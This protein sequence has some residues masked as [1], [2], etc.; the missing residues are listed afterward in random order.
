M[1]EPKTEN[2]KAKRDQSNLEQGHNGSDL[3]HVTLAPY[4]LVGFIST[5]IGIII[6]VVFNLS[7]PLDFIRER[8]FGQSETVS[9]RAFLAFFIPR[10]A[11]ILSIAYTAVYLGIRYL[12]MPISDCL[13]V[14]RSGQE[15]Q[16]EK[17]FN[18]QKR[19]LNLSFLFF[20]LNISIWILLPAGVGLG[21]ILTG[22]TDKHTAMILSVRA[23]M[24]GLIA[25]AIASQ[26]IESISRQALIPFFFPHGQLSRLEGVSKVTL[27]K[28]I[29]MINRLGAVIPMLILLVTLL[30]LQWQQAIEPTS[31]FDYG[32]G[33]IIFTLV[34]FVWTLLFSRELNRLLSKNI[35]EPINHMVQVLRNVHKGEYDQHLQVV[36]NDEIGYAG[37]VVNEMTQGL[38]EREEM[39]QSLN[40]ARQIQQSLLPKQ[41]PDIPGLDIAGASTYCDETGGDY[42]DFLMP[43]DPSNPAIRIVLGDVSGHG[44]SSALLMT[45]SRALFRQRSAMPGDLNDVVTQVNELLCRDVEDSGNFMTLFCIEANP[46]RNR[47]KWVRAG[48]DPA[49]LY[50]TETEAFTELKGTG[51]ALG[52]DDTIQYDENE[53]TGLAKGHIAVLYTDGIWEAQ[54]SRG[55]QFGK[56]RLK[57]L[58]RKHKAL[59]ADALLKVL[60]DAS[61][62]FQEGEKRQDDA[63]LIIIKFLDEPK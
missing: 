61:I 5:T 60:M 22:I 16:K 30:T 51:M 2:G 13:A 12:L 59:P 7:T 46:V 39:Q 45:T 32:R 35:V 4:Y 3:S 14:Y 36:S 56:D 34:L 44:I 28:R 41:N 26:R 37:D 42:Y 1:F 54:N 11:F 62:R 8:I 23:S 24:V 48:H 58:I 10:L 52:V 40:L 18:A 57:A 43:D 53:V 15:P 50:N 29:T 27:S 55:D 6:V 19:L 49:I 25:S 21:S 47:I 17:V 38:R 31:A 63:T 33:V 20:P 9:L